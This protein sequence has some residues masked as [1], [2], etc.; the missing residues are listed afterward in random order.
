M[1]RAPLDDYRVTPHGG[2]GQ[3]RTKPTD[4]RCGYK[5]V[6]PCVHRGLDMA[7]PAGGAV[8]APENGRVVISV[9]D[10]VTPPLR[11]FGPGAILF[12]GDSGMR[13]VLGHMDPTW[14]E[15]SAWRGFP[16]ALPKVLIP[17][18]VPADGRRYRQGEQM[19][20]VAVDHLHWEV[21]DRD[22]KRYDPEGWARG[23]TV[24]EGGESQS[25]VLL[26]LAL[27]VLAD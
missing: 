11:G 25:W 2:F 13:H 9:S 20:V 12:L 19:G 27:A 18:R 14:W 23:R 5:N 7:A 10:N 21:R 26:I 8:Y 16:G 3:S 17:D 1:P 15:N 4:G 22:G 6:Y 24:A